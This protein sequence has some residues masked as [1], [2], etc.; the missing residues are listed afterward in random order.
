MLADGHSGFLSEDIERGNVYSGLVLDVLDLQ[1]RRIEKCLFG[2][3]HLA[4]VRKRLIS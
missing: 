2:W 4:S 3:L 1:D